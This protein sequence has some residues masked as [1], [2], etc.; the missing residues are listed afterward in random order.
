MTDYVHITVESNRISLECAQEAIFVV[1]LDH[2]HANPTPPEN[3][4]CLQNH[5][6]ELARRAKHLLIGGGSRANGMNR[7]YDATIQL[8]VS[9]NGTNGLCIEH[10][11]AEGIVSIN[12]AES[13]LR[14]ERENRKQR[15]MGEAEKEIH[16]RPLSWDV[17][18][19]AVM[20]LEKQKATMNELTD[21]LDLKVLIFNDFGRDFIK[22]H[23][24]SPDGF[25]QLALQLA[26]FKL[27]G[28]VVCT[29][30][31]ASL[32]RYR[33]G[34]VDN[35]RANTMEALEWVRAMTGESSEETKLTLVRKAADKQAKVTEEIQGGY[36]IDNH[37]YALYVLAKQ[38]L[39]SGTIPELPV[40]F[41]DFMWNELMRFPLSTSQVF[42]TNFCGEQVKK[43]KKNNGISR[44]PHRL[45]FLTAFSAMVLLF[46]M[47]TAV[48][49]I[50]RMTP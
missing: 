4:S 43:K 1:C 49:I 15:Q 27:H 16:A 19:E 41:R 17:N 21:E 36:G 32:R 23:Q 29:Y 5:E 24:F 34:R 46:V 31:T 30:E 35:I 22:T 37:L 14:Y 42:Y 39:E 13:A 45:T 10:S 2:E 40:F 12:M 11:T 20:L 26:H 25:V 6:E 48:R 3:S 38:S 47:D 44:S 28:Y 7:W 50:F 33:T 8:I 18:P 9:R